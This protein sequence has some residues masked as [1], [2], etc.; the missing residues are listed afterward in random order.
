MYIYAIKKDNKGYTLVPEKFVKKV[1]P[2]ENGA[3]HFELKWKELKERDKKRFI[4][5]SL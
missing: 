2:N 4:R 1:I 3:K 5:Y